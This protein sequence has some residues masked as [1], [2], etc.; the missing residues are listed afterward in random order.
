MI[1]TIDGPAG[2]GKSSVSRVLASRLGF[3]FLDTGA[4][5][6]A[7][8]WAAMQQGISL[9]DDDALDDLAARI[10][11]A[12]GE[13]EVL[14][15]GQIAT[16][17]IRDPEVTRN[18]SAIADNAQVRKHLVRLQREY[19]KYG[20]Y[21]CEG[22]DQGTVAFPNAFCKFFLTASPEQRARR[23]ADQMKASGRKVD[24]LQLL[25]QQNE[26]DQRD[27]NRPVGR[28][29]QADD[30]IVVNTDDMTFDEVVGHLEA[31]VREKMLGYLSS[32]N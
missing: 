26:R 1:V 25:D 18:V 6:R 24:E 17:Q 3:Q 20:N 8:T 2:A 15:D 19:A 7:V 30:A 21:V 12:F 10:Q 14:V 27:C 5:Y 11:I 32:P 16:E 23:R 22:R 13:G 4:M 31:I 28:L 29:L 9:D